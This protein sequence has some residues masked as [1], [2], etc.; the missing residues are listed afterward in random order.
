[1]QGPV[2]SNARGQA[3]IDLWR[4]AA[5]LLTDDIASQASLLVTMGCG[6]A[7]PVGPGLAA[8]ERVS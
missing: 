8:I 4:T 5:H 3:G 1:M 7:C 2:R 6:E